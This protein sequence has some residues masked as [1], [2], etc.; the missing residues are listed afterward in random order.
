MR[1]GAVPK[2]TGA[3]PYWR[4]GLGLECI[5]LVVKCIRFWQRV[6]YGVESWSGV[7]EW[8]HGVL[9]HVALCT[10]GITLSR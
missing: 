1:T 8:S 10:G 4:S 9:K 3:V 5:S 6:I 7:S 2:W